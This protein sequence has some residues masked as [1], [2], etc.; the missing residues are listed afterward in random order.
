MLMYNKWMDDAPSLDDTEE[1]DTRVSAPSPR[2]SALPAAAWFYTIVES[3]KTGRAISTKNKNS[4]HTH[5][6]CMRMLS[7]PI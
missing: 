3:K 6:H 2:A 4:N 1:D 7:V 5:M